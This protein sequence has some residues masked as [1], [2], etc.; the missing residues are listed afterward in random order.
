MSY[1]LDALK[2]SE[3]ERGQGNI[4]DVQ[5]VHS[6]SL[7]YRNEKKA[8]WPYFLIAAVL[9]NLLA[10]IYFITEKQT[11]EKTAALSSKTTGNEQATINKENASEI[12]PPEHLEITE[13]ATIIVSKKTETMVE[14]EEP[15]NIKTDNSKPQ[16]AE[17]SKSTATKNKAS[18]LNNETEILAFHELPENIIT[19]ICYFC[20][21]LFKQPHATKHCYQ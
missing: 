19:I 11:P 8:Y 17:N 20:T 18:S 21:R 4:P 15:E 12:K 13:Q 14:K 2:K 1:I 16:A 5:T 9:L 6:S 10:I 3:Q 7:N